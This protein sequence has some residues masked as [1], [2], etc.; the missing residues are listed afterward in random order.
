MSAPAKLD[1]LDRGSATE[2][3]DLPDFPGP[4]ESRRTVLQDV[5]R[6]GAARRRSRKRETLRERIEERRVELQ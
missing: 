6:M 5:R 4:K 1:L 2:E 3:V